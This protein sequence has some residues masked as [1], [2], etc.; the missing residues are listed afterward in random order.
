MLVLVVWLALSPRPQLLDGVSFSPIV[1]DRNGSLL[2]LGLTKDGKYRLRVHLRDISPA[3]VHALLRYEDRFFYQHLGVNPFS[4]IRAL[5]NSLFGGRRM[6]GSTLTMQ[7]VRLRQ[8]LN[9][10]SVFGKL[11]QIFSALQLEYHYQKDEI[12]EAYCNLAPYGGNVEG[13]EAT[14]RIWF[15]KPARLLSQSEGLALAIVPQHPA[16][17]HPLHGA[18]FHSARRRITKVWDKKANPLPL[19]LFDLPDLPFEAPHLCTEL[20]A[21]QSDAEPIRTTIDSSLQHLLEKFLRQF[22]ARH[23]AYDLSNAA[24]MLVHWPS[25]EVRALVGSANFHDTKIQGQVDGTRAKRSPGS[26]LKPFIYALALEQGLIHPMSLLADSPKS[27]GG[28]DPENFDH[29]FRGP[30]SAREALQS[31]RNIPAIDLASRLRP[32]GL[33]GF[34]QRAGVDLLFS[35]EHYGLSL[36]LGGAEV[37]LRD[38]AKLYAMLPNQGLL[39]DLR[40]TSTETSNPPRRMLAPESAFMTLAMLEKD[41]EF[42]PASSENLPLRLKTGTSNGF[43]DAWTAGIFGQYVLVVWVGNFDNHANPLL[44]GGEIAEPLFKDMAR[45]ILATDSENLH[46]PIPEQVAGFNLTKI[47]VCTA[48]GDVDTSLCP[49]KSL[50]WFWPGVSPVRSSGV[51]RTILI[52]RTSG[53]RACSPISGQTEEKVWEFWSTDLRRLFLRAGIVKTPPPPW[54]FEGPSCLGYQKN[55]LSSVGQQPRILSPREGLT[56]QIRLSA[57]SS[58]P[59]IAATEA[60]SQQIFWFAGSS[61]LGNTPP[62]EALAWHPAAGITELRAVDDKGRTTLQRVQIESVP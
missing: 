41:S 32:P 20:L 44:I 22:V 3:S 25:M 18:D 24:A 27:F 11:Q 17:R 33:Y 5:G 6:G 29:T 9:T 51:F 43:R 21:Q 40:F 1:L 15:H 36:V 7:V 34:L 62:G 59:L 14:A 30:L 12:L 4:L 46:D 58:I 53:L 23:R 56:Y 45:A 13:L 48:T 61:F 38:L 10:K 19:R 47:P 57:P 31:S 50:T 2:R 55:Q 16:R 26:T 37:S 8:G 54:D 39:R 60:D 35:E 42:L 52:D 49:E 28:Y